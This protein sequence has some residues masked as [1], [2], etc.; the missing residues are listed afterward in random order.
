VGVYVKR[1]GSIAYIEGL[2]RTDIGVRKAREVLDDAIDEL[3]YRAALHRFRPLPWD[4]YT[5]P[6]NAPY[7]EHESD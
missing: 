1:K 5:E 4:V 7:T 6:V 3:N 2:E